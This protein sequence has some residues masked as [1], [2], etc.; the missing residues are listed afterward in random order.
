MR[1]DML[2]SLKFYFKGFTKIFNLFIKILINKFIFQRGPQGNY[3]Y[4][5]NATNG[6]GISQPQMLY[7]SS[8]ALKLEVINNSYPPIEQK[9]GV[10]FTI[11]P[12]VKVTDYYG[13]PLQNKYIIAVSWPEPFVPLTTATSAYQAAYLDGKVYLD[14]YIKN[15]NKSY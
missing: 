15:F 10:P 9:I 14:Y 6:S 7:I 13:N 4:Q 1:L 12:I 2:H 3:Q 5:Y 8:E 11:Q